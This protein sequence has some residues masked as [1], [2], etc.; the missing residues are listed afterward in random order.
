MN[1]LDEA[2][3]ALIGAWGVYISNET[4]SV[5]WQFYQF[6]SME[7][8][9]SHQDRIRADAQLSKAQEKKLYAQLNEVNTSILRLADVSPTLLAE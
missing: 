7:N 9:E 8:W 5:V 4:G 2:G 3:S 6:D 1:A